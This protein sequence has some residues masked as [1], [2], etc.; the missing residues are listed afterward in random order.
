[1]KSGTITHVGYTATSP[2]SAGDK[3]FDARTGL[4]RVEEAPGAYHRALE[5]GV[6]VRPLLFETYGGWSP[7]VVELFTE[8]ANERSNKLDKHEYDQATWATRTWLSWVVQKVS[9]AL[10][11]AAALEVAHALGLSAAVDERA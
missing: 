5:K 8:L 3:P 6:D 4:G 1:M 7:E 11:H 9:V 2:P 10:H